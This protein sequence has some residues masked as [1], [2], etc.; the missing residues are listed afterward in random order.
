MNVFT[1]IQVG[2][3]VEKE[4]LRLSNF[5]SGDWP[6][7]VPSDAVGGDVVHRFQQPGVYPVVFVVCGQTT[8]NGEEQT[9]QVE[10]TVTVIA[11]PTLQVRRR[12]TYRNN[13]VEWR[14]RGVA[15]ATSLQYCARL[16]PPPAAGTKTRRVLRARGTGKP[17]LSHARF[18]FQPNCPIFGR[19]ARTSAPLAC[20]VWRE[21]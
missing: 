5:T 19:P 7:A 15:V 4:Q 11:N 12:I 8:H 16:T 20:S 21:T 18:N 6:S 9:T 10:T 14:V 2:S 13:S 17:R 3:G 1:T